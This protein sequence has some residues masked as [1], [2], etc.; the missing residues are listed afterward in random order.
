[1]IKELQQNERDILQKMCLAVLQ[2]KIE[3]KHKLTA[4]Y[5]LGK[6]QG[7]HIR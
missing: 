7:G 2:G 3:E 5:F 1:M 4:S 6:I